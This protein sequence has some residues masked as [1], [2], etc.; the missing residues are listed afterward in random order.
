MVGERGQVR[1]TGSRTVSEAVGAVSDGSTSISSSSTFED[2][3]GDVNDMLM[4]SKF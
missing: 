4:N 3:Y 1:G 2:I